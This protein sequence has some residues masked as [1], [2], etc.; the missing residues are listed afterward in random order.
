MAKM[1]VLNPSATRD[2]LDDGNM[3]GVFQKPDEDMLAI[4][5]VAI[6]ETRALIEEGWE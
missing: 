5:D 3:G 2:Y 4:W 6:E 1:E